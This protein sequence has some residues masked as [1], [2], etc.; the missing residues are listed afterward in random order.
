MLDDDDDDEE[1]SDGERL[2]RLRFFTGV[3]LR[4]RCLNFFFLS[5]LS[6]RLS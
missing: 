4:L 2:L 6:I 1:V 3:R 5:F